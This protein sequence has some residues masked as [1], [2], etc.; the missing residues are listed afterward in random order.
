MMDGAT[1]YKKYKREPKEDYYGTVINRG[2][3]GVNRDFEQT[4]LDLLR[5]S[6]EKSSSIHKRY[7]KQG[8]KQTNVSASVHSDMNSSR[9]RK[10]EFGKHREVKVVENLTEIDDMRFERM[11]YDVTQRVMNEQN[12][13]MD[14]SEDKVKLLKMCSSKEFKS[15]LKSI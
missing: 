6:E 11:C 9:D 1:R 15:A 5:R 7:Y 10:F 2:I 8:T 3:V 4:K 13:N 14:V 12:K